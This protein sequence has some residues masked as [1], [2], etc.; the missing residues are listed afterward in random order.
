MIAN[1]SESILLFKRNM[2]PLINVYS[3]NFLAVAALRVLL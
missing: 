2:K 3:N 1:G